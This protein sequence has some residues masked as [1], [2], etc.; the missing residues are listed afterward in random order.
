M[1]L[2]YE[3]EGDWQARAAE[4]CERALSVDPQLPEGRYLRGSLLWTPRSGFDHVGAMRELVAAIAGRPS[5]SEAHTRLSVVL[6]HASM[7]EESLSAS[8]AAV[9]IDPAD[10]LALIHRGLAHYHLGQYERALGMSEQ[11]STQTPAAWIYHQIAHC[12]IRLGRRSEAAAV[13]DRT[14]RQFPND[15]LFYPVRGVI[16]ASERD[17]ERARQQIQLTIQNKKSFVHYHHAQYD[18]ACIHA[19]LGEKDDALRWLADAAHNG[20][21]CHG[22]FEIDPLLESIRGEE[23]FRGLMSELREECAGY[24]RLYEELRRSHSGSAETAA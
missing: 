17:A 9:A 15:V 13:V 2:N 8:Q 5:L 1:A 12:L 4:M 6:D 23:R 24:R 22:F 7:F 18:I 10:G 16:A 14:S 20:F 19:L 21:P 3:P 11:A